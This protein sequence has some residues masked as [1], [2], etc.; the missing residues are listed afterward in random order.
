MKKTLLLTV[1]STLL[2]GQQGSWQL[3]SSSFSESF[4]T[5]YIHSSGAIFIGSEMG[6]IYY[7]IDG[8]T[9]WD[10]SNTGVFDGITDITFITATEAWA[11]GD[12]GLILKSTD[13]GLNWSS[14]TSGVQ[15]NLEAIHFANSTT[16]YIA[17]RDG[18]VLMSKN[19]GSSWASLNNGT[20]NRLESVFFTSATTGFVA[21]RDGTFI[22]TTDG[23]STWSNIN[24]GSDDNKEVYFINSNTGIVA[25]ENGIF[26]S[27]DGG[28]TWN[29]AN[30][31]GINEVNAMHFASSSI[32]YVV[33]EQGD[34]G[35]SL[36]G[37]SNWM[38]DTLISSINNVELND[39]YFL[40][41]QLGFAVGDGAT[42]LKFGRLP[43]GPGSFCNAS[44]WVDTNL[45]GGSNLFV[46]NNSIPLP[47]NSAYNTTYYWDFGDGDTST[48]RLPTHA[49]VNA[50]AYNLCLTIA[51]L[52][53]SNNLCTSTFCDSIG[54]DSLG[55]ILHKSSQGF[56]LN[57][58]DSGS[59][60]ISEAE[61]NLISIYPNP[62]N[63]ILWID[64]PREWENH[65]I[66]IR[67][68][69]GRRALQTIFNP[70]VP[71][72]LSNIPKGIYTL[73]MSGNKGTWHY[74]KIILR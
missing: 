58:I 64:A 3:L 48:Q 51:S 33:G 69:Q 18:T 10:T 40:S 67:D 5:T 23:G 63:G 31:T 61:L 70:A 24:L 55:N 42:L 30:T 7:S 59:I 21:G 38:M 1:L 20:N 22:K 71:I 62:A 43:S 9:T 16:A 13:A 54:L 66:I 26:K 50:G 37:G 68:A 25:G 65:E 2:Y 44:F 57:I 73:S 47:G 35:V 56:T 60:G 14:I 41:P 46:V 17:G 52:D 49:H 19:G 36:D 34:I 53:S 12:D 8:G 29:A 11:V 72:D 28:S 45:S 32:G 27:T 39:V 74:Q 6:N 4:N 15:V